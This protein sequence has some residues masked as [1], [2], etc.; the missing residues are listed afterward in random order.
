MTAVDLSDPLR[1]VVQ[2]VAIVGDGDDGAGVGGQVLLQPQHR[3]R[4][5]VVRG[6]VEEEQVGLLQQQLAQCDATA[7]TAGEV[8]HLHVAGRAAQCVHRLLQLRVQVPG[9]RVV[10][11]LLELAHLLHEGVEVRIGARHLLGDL[12]EAVQ[13]ALDVCDGLLHVAADRLLL[14]ERGLLEEDAHGVAGAQ[15]GFAV[16]GLID[17]RHDLEDGGL[18]GA[19]GAD[20]ADL[21]SGIERHR[22]IVEDD[23]VTVRLA[24]LVHGVNELCHSATSL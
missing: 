12:V 4:V 5:Q 7:L 8:R 21:R 16:G 6:L 2:E 18:A 24:R 20:H 14:V 23:L 1:H 22:H 10:D 11:R 19:V 13:L 17:A 9:V 3:L 15:A